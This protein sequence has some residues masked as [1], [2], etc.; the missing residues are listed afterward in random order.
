MS[1]RT[2]LFLVAASIGAL[3]L[4]LATIL[5]R[6]RGLDSIAHDGVVAILQD[7]SAALY[8][9]HSPEEETRGGLTEAS[10]KKVWDQLVKPR[11]ARVEFSKDIVAQS[12]NE[13][14]TQG[15]ASVELTLPDRTNYAVSLAV[16]PTKDGPK[17]RLLWDLLT[18]MWILDYALEHP[19]EFN[20]RSINPADMKLAG[21]RHDRA[22]LE[23]LGLKGLL[24]RRGQFL[25]WQQVD[26]YFTKESKLY[27]AYAGKHGRP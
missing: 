3:L 1:T 13:P 25:T 12:L 26:E 9:L 21:L 2:K 14:P 24:N 15:D 11:L 6:P 8:A 19:M 22:Q 20:L 4:L 18:Q 23:N 7:N 27:R 10:F 17:V 16:W 5:P